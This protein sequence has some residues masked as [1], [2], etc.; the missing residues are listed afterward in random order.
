MIKQTLTATWTNAQG[1]DAS[2]RERVFAHEMVK[3]VDGNIE[4]LRCMHNQAMAVPG[5]PSRYWALYFSSIV[6]AFSDHPNR[7]GEL[8]QI[9]M[10]LN[11]HPVLDN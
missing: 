1:N 8:G 6:R 5:V 4:A 2:M 10:Q 11:F 9:M 7:N 3:G